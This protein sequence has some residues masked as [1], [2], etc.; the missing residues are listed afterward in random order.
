[1]KSVLGSTVRTCFAVTLLV[2]ESA[3]GYK[4]MSGIKI[5][6]PLDLGKVASGMKFGD[7]KLAVITGTSSGLGKATTKSLLRDEGYHVIGAVRDLEKMKVVAEVEGFDKD[8]FT[9]MHLDLAS[10]DSVNKFVQ[11]LDAFR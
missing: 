7:K 11:E 9:A 8:R 4:W 2:L 6:T 1:M 3:Q 5:P 10:F